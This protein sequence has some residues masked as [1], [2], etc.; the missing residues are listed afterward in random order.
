[1]GVLP[2]IGRLAIYGGELTGMV[3]PKTWDLYGTSFSERNIPS[4]SP[5][6]CEETSEIPRQPI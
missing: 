5:T 3:C 4:S 6:L 1:M 2:K